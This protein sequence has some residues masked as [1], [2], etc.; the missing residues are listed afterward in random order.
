M[1]DD[2]VVKQITIDEG[3][4]ETGSGITLEVAEHIHQLGFIFKVNL[5]I[6]RCR[7]TPQP[8]WMIPGYEL[9]GGDFMQLSNGS[10]YRAIIFLPCIAQ[11]FP[12]NP[13]FQ[14]NWFISIEKYKAATLSGDHLIGVITM[15]SEMV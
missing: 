13:F 15:G 11:G 8:I 3:L 5:V 9:G 6:E 10:T 7:H 2:I 14:D 12:M 1:V 4:G